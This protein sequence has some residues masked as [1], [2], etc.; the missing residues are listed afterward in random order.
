[1]GDIIKQ[2]SII[3]K[4]YYILILTYMSVHLF[5]LLKVEKNIKFI[6]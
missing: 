5:F 2:L 4:N 6:L 3:A 1:M